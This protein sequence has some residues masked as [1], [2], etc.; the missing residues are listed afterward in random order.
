MNHLLDAP[1]LNSPY[2][3]KIN[4]TQNEPV[5]CL[6]PKAIRSLLAL[7]DQHA[8]N[9]GAACHWGGP[10]AIAEFLSCIHEI[11][12]RETDW[13]NH[14]N[15]VNDIG[16]AENALYAVK[17]LYGYG[18]LNFESLKG[19]RSIDSK[20]TG[21]GESHLYPEGVLMSNGPLGSAF[22]QAQGLAM[23]DKLSNN[24]RVTITLI[25]D[26]ACMEG[27]AKEA[28]AA[29][30]G[31]FQKGMINPFLLV[32]S[33]NKTKLSGRIHDAFSMQPTF[34]SL[35]ALGWNIMTL[36]QG[37]DLEKTYQATQKAISASQNS[38]TV[39]WMKTVKGQGIKATQDSDS[40]GHGFPLKKADGK[41][42]AF[43]DELWDQKAPDDF[44]N[45]ANELNAI[46]VDKKSGPAKEKMQVG[47]SKALIE[48]KNEGLPIIS[49]SSDLQGSTGLK[50]FHQEFPKASIDIGIAESN[51]VSVAAGFSK[52]DYIPVV[53]TFAAFGITKG[54]LPLIMAS[55]SSSPM[56]CVFSHT[57][58]QDAA[59]GAS[60][61]S[62]T[63]FSALASIPNV[64]IIAPANSDDTYRLMKHFV[65]KQHQDKLKN[66]AKSYVF[67]LGR[68]T[69]IPSFEKND[70]D[71]ETDQLLFE[72]KD[73]LII[74]T[75]ALV[76]E[77]LKARELLSAQGKNYGIINHRHL[78]TFK[79]SVY[80]KWINDHQGN[81]LTLEDHQVNHGI[82]A[83]LTHKIMTQTNAKI[84]SIKSLGVKGIFGQSAYTATEL[85]KKHGLDAKSIAQNILE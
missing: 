33:D 26:G 39:L 50:P 32:I 81:I 22:P 40:G 5:E 27:E 64:E 19:F 42:A 3:L 52:N 6:D 58:F 29:V 45:W 30:P 23:S 41:I 56:I 77:A 28:M 2:T 60:H 1:K 80:E 24:K 13:Y 21:H 83:S 8:V 4:S 20:L 59:D 16:H 73:G 71:I 34:D 10:S 65:K 79:S 7:M 63:Y 84:N 53:D 72:G 67:F 62:L 51:M 44:K 25:S 46:T 74:A 57:G 36:E 14:Y 35:K 82:G 70:N 38:P 78:N 48:L 43:I 76:H 12:F 47:V 61:Q 75:G 54:N 68:E 37:H 15:F 18:G 85:Y 11:M 55:L 9:G 17:A 31:L 69:F 49:I 66:H